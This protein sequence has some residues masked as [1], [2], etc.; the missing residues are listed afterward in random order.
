MNT[1]LFVILYLGL[2][3]LL[4]FW[5]YSR[6]NSFWAGLLISLFFSPVIGFFSVILASPNQ[7]GIEKH[8]V[9][10][11]KMKRCPACKELVQPDAVKCKH[12]GSALA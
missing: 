8:L 4:A 12:C 3:L 11:G 10:A 1:P 7:A 6:G 2:C 5:N 9:K